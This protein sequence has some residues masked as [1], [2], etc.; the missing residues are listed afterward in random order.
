MVTSRTRVF[1]VF[2]LHPP[3]CSGFLSLCFF[4]HQFRECDVVTPSCKGSWWWTIQFFQPFSRGG[5]QEGL[6]MAG[7]LSSQLVGIDQLWKISKNKWVLNH[8]HRKPDAPGSSLCVGCE[9][10]SKWECYGMEGP[11]LGPLPATWP[12]LSKVCVWH[13]SLDS[14]KVILNPAGWKWGIRREEAKE[15]HFLAH[16]TQKQDCCL[17]EV[18]SRAL[19]ISL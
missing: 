11:L 8:H 13:C 4:S 17:S 18:N 1:S 5:G 6:G 14:G 19:L 3:W 15:G 2:L 7:G 9:W 16:N 12:I 10:S